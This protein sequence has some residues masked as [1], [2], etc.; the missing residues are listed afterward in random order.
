[1]FGVIVVAIVGFFAFR[2]HRRQHSLSRTKARGS[3]EMLRNGEGSG[4]VERK[5][6]MKGPGLPWWNWRR[7][8]EPEEETPHYFPL[9]ERGRESD[10]YI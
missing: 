8:T 6:P 4:M 1:M 2:W 3:S 10:D 5:V 7:W 9:A